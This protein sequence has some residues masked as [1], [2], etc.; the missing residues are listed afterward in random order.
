MWC[1]MFLLLNLN[2]RLLW[3]LY[4]VMDFNVLQAFLGFKW[5]IQR[6]FKLNFKDFMTVNMK[7]SPGNQ[8]LAVFLFFLHKKL[9]PGHTTV[10]ALIRY[11]WN[12]SLPRKSILYHW[13][14]NLYGI[15][16]QCTDGPTCM[17]YPPKVTDFF[18]AGITE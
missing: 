14:I 17:V 3:V 1:F 16:A 13:E 10:I 7:N 2:W 6:I 12:H 8:G 18:F 15:A 4:I 9:S 5:S 11:K